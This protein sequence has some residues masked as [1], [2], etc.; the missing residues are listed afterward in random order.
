MFLHMGSLRSYVALETSRCPLVEIHQSSF[1]G[2]MYT[3]LLEP[4]PTE[5]QVALSSKALPSLKRYTQRRYNSSK[6]TTL[7]T[8]GQVWTA[9]GNICKCKQLPVLILKVQRDGK[10]H[11]RICF[12]LPIS[13]LLAFTSVWYVKCAG[14]WDYYSADPALHS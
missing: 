8:Q 11:L 1:P 7:V 9:V 12:A 5:F 2:A 3:P 10:A 13:P 6:I 14:S 4:S